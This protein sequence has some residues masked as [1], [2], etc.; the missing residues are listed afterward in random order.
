MFEPYSELLN[1]KTSDFDKLVEKSMAD[2]TSI[3]M[4]AIAKNK[5]NYLFSKPEG[6]FKESKKNKTGALDEHSIMKRLG[7]TV[8]YDLASMGESANPEQHLLNCLEKGIG[9]LNKGRSIRKREKDKQDEEG[10]LKDNIQKKLKVSNLDD[11][12]EDDEKIK[13]RVS[14]IL[15]R[16]VDVARILLFNQI[17]EV[18]HGASLILR[19]VARKAEYFYYFRHMSAPGDF[20]V[21]RGHSVR[22]LRS[23]IQEQS[24]TILKEILTDSVIRNL[25]IIGLDRFSDYASDESNIIVR[26]ISSQGISHALKFL[27]DQ[28]LTVKMIEFFTE[29]LKRDISNGWE[30]KQGSIFLMTDLLD[31]IPALAKAFSKSFNALIISM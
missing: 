26:K 31:K 5:Q 9:S 16:I 18:R 29:I 17:W 14:T 3:D 4:M 30:P 11:M 25:L 13:M 21:N 23:S 1:Q 19:A 15:I 2:L 10:E 12:N 24:N 22:Q 27:K 28:N 8:S 6:T 7:G 20:K